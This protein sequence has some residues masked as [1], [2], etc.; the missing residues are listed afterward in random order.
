MGSASDT[1]ET[2]LGKVLVQGVTYTALATKYLCIGTY[3]DDGTFTEIPN[4]NGYSR[5]AITMSAANWPEDGTIK[6][7]FTN[8]VV[9]TSPTAS[10]SWGTPTVLG[11]AR[12]GTYG[13]L[14]IDFYGL[15][16]ASTVQAIGSGSALNL[17]VG[18]VVLTVD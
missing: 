15:I 18:T 11:F 10:G 4:A 8:N 13:V 7:K 3:A 16:D 12:A 17:A 6:G 5:T 2:A 1:A 9:I 14:D